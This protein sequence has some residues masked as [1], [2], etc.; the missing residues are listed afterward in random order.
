MVRTHYDHWYSLQVLIFWVVD[1]FLMK[2]LRLPGSR[3]KL[4]KYKKLQQNTEE[5]GESIEMVDEQ[6]YLSDSSHKHDL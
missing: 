2:T 4:H 3:S 6:S 1:N 5:D